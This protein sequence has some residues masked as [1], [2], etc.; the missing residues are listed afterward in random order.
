V[1][2]PALNG[3]PAWLEKIVLLATPACARDAVAGDLWE[4]YRTPTHYAAEALRTV[5]RVVASQMRRN[6]NLPAI[7]LQLALT[8]IC[9]GRVAAAVLCPLLLL[10][11][12]YLPAARPSHRTALRQAVLVAFSGVVLIQLALLGPPSTDA[13]LWVEIFFIGFLLLPFL[14]LIRAAL[15]MDSD[16]Q[17][18]LSQFPSQEAAAAGLRDFAAA[19][20]RRNRMEALALLAMAAFILFRAGGSFS[21]LAAMDAAVAA[22]L[23]VDNGG[24]C[25]ALPPRVQHQRA[26]ARQRQLRGF[27]CWLWLAPLLLTIHSR[28]MEN[29]LGAGRPLPLVLGITA[30]ILLCYPATALNREHSGRIQEQ[31][32]LLE[33]G[34]R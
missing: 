7:M 31:I 27:L 8:E 10:R 15:V 5:P 18:Y 19:S 30:I 22:W 33:S 23:L 4:T 3:P 29:G 25:A 11:D 26:L 14:C 17:P 13:F 34:R 24:I 2:N 21:A 20:R 6:L 16:R 32:R 12:A 9:A 1:E 28:L